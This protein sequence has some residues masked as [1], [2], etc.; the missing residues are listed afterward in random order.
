[1][2]KVTSSNKF[3]ALLALAFSLLLFFNANFPS[4]LFSKDENQ[5]NIRTLEAVVS[6]VPIKLVYDDSQYFVS[7]HQETTTVYLSSTNRLLLDTETNEQTRKFVLE[8]DLTNRQP[9]TY[10]V[11]VEVKNLTS[12]VKAELK[13]PKISVK[14]E[15]RMTKTFPVNVRINDDLLKNGY[16]IEETNVSP[17]EVEITAGEETINSITDVLVSIDQDQQ[18]SSD[19]SNRLDVYAIDAQGN[20]LNVIANPSTVMV[21][22]NVI[23]PMK[24]V[25]LVI[26]QSGKIP[27]GV[28]SY[29][30]TSETQNVEITGP[31]EII[32][33]ID[34]VIALVDTS[35]ITETATNTYS[36]EEIDNVKLNPATVRITVT[37]KLAEKKSETS[38]STKEK[39]GS[40]SEKSRTSTDKN[41][42]SSD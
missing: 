33:D 36:I 29:T 42:S 26:K 2:N 6:D 15:K 24:T 19:F 37:P 39:N 13:D 34:E 18:I 7:G 8:A 27:E 31:R 9:G 22:L 21:S 3:T 38:S 32:D 1:M 30:F 23:A 35:T 11:E 14:L 25:P 4:G 17:S 28:E 5:P 40:T 16:T 12:G 20:V 10:E 41:K